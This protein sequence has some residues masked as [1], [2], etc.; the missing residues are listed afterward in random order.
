M[1]PIDVPIFKDGT[2]QGYLGITVIWQATS[3]ENA[4]K[5]KQA[6]PVLTDLVLTDLYGALYLL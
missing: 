4:E 1:R 6:K 5:I 2:F 3:P